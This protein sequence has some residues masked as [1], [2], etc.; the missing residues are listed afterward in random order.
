VTASLV[1]A[2]TME[3]CSGQLP[4]RSGF[5]ATS[6]RPNPVSIGA[7]AQALGFGDTRSTSL[8]LWTC[9]FSTMEAATR[10]ARLRSDLAAAAGPSLGTAKAPAPATARPCLVRDKVMPRFFQ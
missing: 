6:D 5:V 2:F 8:R 4:F 1:M 3:A 7:P 9:R 10:L